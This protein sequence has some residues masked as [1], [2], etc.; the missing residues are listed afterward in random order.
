[1]RCR[2]LLLM[3]VV[4]VR[5][6]VTPVNS[7]A[8]AVCV[9]SFDAAFAKSVWPLVMSYSHTIR[10]CTYVYFHTLANMCLVFSVVSNRIVSQFFCCIFVPVEKV[11]HFAQHFRACLSLLLLVG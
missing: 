2:L 9:G 5:R 4:S 8:H 3:I 1:M 10:Y 7:V 11:S 6:S